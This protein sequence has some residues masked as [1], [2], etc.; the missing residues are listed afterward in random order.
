MPVPPPSRPA[1][2]AAP[3]LDPPLASPLDPSLDRALDPPLAATAGASR[4]VPV[5]PSGRAS[6]GTALA[7]AGGAAAPAAQGIVARAARPVAG[8]VA[9]LLI[10]ACAASA[11]D[12]HALQAQVADTERAFARTMA[13]RDHDGFQRFLADEAVFFSGAEPLRGKAAV[14]AAWKRFYEAPEAPFSW[15]PERVQV[16]DSGRLAFSSGPVLDPA[17]R[18][19]GRFQSVWRLETPGVWRIV[20]DSGCD[21]P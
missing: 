13:E 19:I 20:F 10:A 5:V 1:R 3:P 9:S 17:G 2:H 16:L 8:L 21:C 12:L 7:E 18:P 4:P 6:H 11:P 15:Q 14:A